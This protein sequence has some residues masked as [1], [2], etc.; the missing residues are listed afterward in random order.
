[1]DKDDE[2]G[3]PRLIEEAERSGRYAEFYIDELGEAEQ[4]DP[5]LYI[6]R[7][8]GALEYHDRRSKA[9]KH[10]A[11]AAEMLDPLTTPPAHIRVCGEGDPAQNKRRGCQD[12]G[13]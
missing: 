2:Y 6:K 9:A 11:A 4:L 8:L 12:G 3:A 7:L 5:A 10:L 13:H 1:M